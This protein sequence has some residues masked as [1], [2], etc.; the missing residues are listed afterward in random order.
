MIGQDLPYS[1]T[2]STLDPAVQDDLGAARGPDHLIAGQ[3]EQVTQQFWI[4]RLKPV[5]NSGRCAGVAVA[6]PGAPPVAAAVPSGDHI[7]GG[8]SMGGDPGSSRH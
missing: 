3:H 7:M 6:E 8:M 4:P 5:M 1:T 2:P